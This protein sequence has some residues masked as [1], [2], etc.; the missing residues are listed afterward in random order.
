MTKVF[1]IKFRIT[2]AVIWIFNQ[3]FISYS[4]MT[5]FPFIIKDKNYGSAKKSEMRWCK[6]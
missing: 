1:Q 6:Q 3:I 2:C 4:K 5:F